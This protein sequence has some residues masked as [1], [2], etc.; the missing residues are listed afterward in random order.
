MEDNDPLPV[1]A[2]LLSSSMFVGDVIAG[3]GLTPFLEAA[4]AAG[5]KTANGDHMAPRRPHPRARRGGGPS[6]R[7]TC[8]AP[9]TEPSRRRG[10]DSWPSVGTR[11]SSGSVARVHGVAAGG[12][13]PTDLERRRGD[14]PQPAVRCT[15]VHSQGLAPAS[16]IVSR[17]ACSPTLKGCDGRQVNGRYRGG[18]PGA[19]RIG[20]MAVPPPRRGPDHRAGTAS[21]AAATA[22]AA[23]S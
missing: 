21:T 22:Y 7:G 6:R 2:P 5:C 17:P 14:Q 1:D 9:M 3:H 16:V 23:R 12:R 20:A 11:R 15:A 10:N 8:W 18:R 4:E 13:D 19:G